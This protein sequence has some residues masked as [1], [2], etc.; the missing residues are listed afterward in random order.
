MNE[1]ANF[2]TIIVES[3]TFNFAILLLLF[4]ILYKKLNVS[5]G[6]EKIKQDIINSI[7]NAKE[8]KAKAENK[9]SQAQKSVENIDNDIAKQLEEAS[10]RADGIASQILNNTNAKVQLIEK[11][12]KRVISAEEKTLSAQI[13][14][15]TLNTS[16]E[17]ARKHIISVLENNH[18][19]HNKFIDESIQNIDR[20]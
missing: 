2:W 7:N 14:K 18:D 10:K 17:I 19:L 9:L 3:N 15:K 1:L 16:I 12:I 6:I 8:E 4:V 11:N 5:G 13:T 20:I